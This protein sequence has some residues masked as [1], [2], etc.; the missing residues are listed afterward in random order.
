M[1]LHSFTELGKSFGI[2][3]KPPREK[4]ITC[5]KCGNL[6]SRVGNTNVYICTGKNTEGDSCM[7]RLILPVKKAQ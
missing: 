5:R 2:K 7:N 4:T 3:A 6:M 1:V